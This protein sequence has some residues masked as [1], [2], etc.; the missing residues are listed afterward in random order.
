M[1]TSAYCIELVIIISNPGTS[2]ICDS[3][4]VRR[5]PGNSPIGSLWHSSSDGGTMNRLHDCTTV[6]GTTAVT[7]ETV[8]TK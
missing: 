7:M 2:R 8:S 3:C 1:T 4:G 6:I 5:D